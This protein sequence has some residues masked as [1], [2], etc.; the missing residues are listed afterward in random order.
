MLL[1]KIVDSDPTMSPTARIAGLV[2]MPASLKLAIANWRELQSKYQ[3]AHK[4]LRRLVAENKA[5]NDTA[6]QISREKH[7]GRLG[8]VLS[9]L[10]AEVGPA[11]R[12][13]QTARAPYLAALEAAL[14]QRETD[15]ARRA[16]CGLE[17]VEA[18]LSDLD[19]VNRELQKAGAEP[20]FY[21]QSTGNHLVGLR[22]RL[23][24]ILC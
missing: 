9:R 21:L 4:E 1:H 16:L 17:S 3:E 11:L 18:A 13:I 24:R 19:E 23:S 2:K 8:E 6:G 20:A 10:A 22:G 5:S 12:A 7:I 14:K 15:A